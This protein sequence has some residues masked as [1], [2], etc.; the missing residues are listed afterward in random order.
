MKIGIIGAGLSGLVL[1]NNLN[2][3]WDIT[4]FEKARG[5]GGRMATRH[6]DPY[7]FDHGA[8]FFTA[9]QKEFKKF[10]QPLLDNG[11]V[12]E[13]NPIMTTLAKGEKP[14]KRDWFE[15]HY[16]PVPKMN[17]MCKYL[18][19][20]QDIYIQKRIELIQNKPN[21][22]IVIDTDGVEYDFDWV[23]STAPAD[24]AQ[25]LVPHD[26]QYFDRIKKLSLM[27]CFTMMVGYDVEPKLHWDAAKVKDSPIEWIA[28]NNSKA[29]RD[30]KPSFTI[31]STNQWALDNLEK[32]IGD[33]QET[34]LSE[35]IDLTHINETPDHIQT[36]RWRYAYAKDKS[37]DDII[38]FFMD[39]NMQIAICGDWCIGGR[40]EAAFT[41]AMEL[42]KRLNSL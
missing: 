5:V 28:L 1:A 15:P 42:A 32:P 4:L 36:H 13:W 19:R 8:Q 14:Y 33:I 29:D 30:M 37:K 35:F 7:Q 34:L 18:A 39:D 26:F 12:V 20:D 17:S 10:L 27:P 22:N 2:D 24:Q 21:K 31:H 3:K 6:A 41:S 11:L 25:N 16:I 9:R 38:P 23:I 40:V